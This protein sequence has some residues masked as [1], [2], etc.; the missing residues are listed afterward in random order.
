MEKKTVEFIKVKSHGA[1]YMMDHN[2]LMHCPME[3]SG[4]PDLSNMGSVEQSP[5]S[6]KKKHIEIMKKFGLGVNEIHRNINS[7][8]YY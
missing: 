8:N 7:I 6:F 3:I 5:K 4:K 2:D 1:I